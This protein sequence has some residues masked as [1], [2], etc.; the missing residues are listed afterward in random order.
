MRGNTLSKLLLLLIYLYFTVFALAA[1]EMTIGTEPLAPEE[2]FVMDHIIVG[3][4]ET[5]IRW[6]ILKFYYLYKEKFIFSSKEFFI[7]NIRFPVPEIMEDPFFGSSEVYHDL[8]EVTLSLKPK[9]KKIMTGILNVTY[10]GC[11]EGGICYPPSKN[12]IKVSLL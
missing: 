1:E 9:T 6:Q 11:W 2:A 7:D 12:S 4:S 3:P 10:Q 5:V 8:V